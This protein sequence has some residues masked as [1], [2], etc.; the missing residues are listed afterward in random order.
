MHHATAGM[1]MAA[2][3]IARSFFNSA[4][5]GVAFNT[6]PVLVARG[7]AARYVADLIAFV[8]AG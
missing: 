7:V 8:K 3:T 4:S 2:M 1:A 5:S 6:V